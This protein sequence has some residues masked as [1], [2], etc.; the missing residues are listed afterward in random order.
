MTP[1]ELAREEKYLREEV[2][3]AL[4]EMIWAAKNGK[5]R[6]LKDAARR[7]EHFHHNLE[8]FVDAAWDNR[9]SQ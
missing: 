9:R 8:R 5:K 1:E 7:W 3:R 4:D 6:D 2:R